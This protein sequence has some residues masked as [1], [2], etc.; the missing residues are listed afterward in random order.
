MGE[1]FDPADFSFV[2]KRRGGSLKLW[3]WEIAAEPGNV[4]KRLSAGAM[5]QLIPPET[6]SR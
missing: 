6:W 4:R 5:T 1:E 3:V 2:V